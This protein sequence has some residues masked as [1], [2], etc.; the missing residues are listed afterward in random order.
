MTQFSI[1]HDLAHFQHEEETRRERARE[2]C[3]RE[4]LMLTCEQR[5]VLAKQTYVPASLV[6]KPKQLR[7]YAL[8]FSEFG[9]SRPWTG[10][11][12]A[13]AAALHRTERAAR[14]RI[15]DLEATGTLK[16]VRRPGQESQ[17]RLLQERKY[18]EIPLA[19]VLRGGCAVCAV[20]ASLRTTLGRG[21]SALKCATAITQV[22]WATIQRITGLGRTAVAEALRWLRGESWLS[23]RK[24]WASLRP[25]RRA[26]CR[27]KLCLRTPAAMRTPPRNED[28]LPPSGRGS[29]NVVEPQAG[30]SKNS[31]VGMEALKAARE[32]GAEGLDLL[33]E[34]RRHLDMLPT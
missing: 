32:S 8:L 18:V 4:M 19:L 6:N 13:I 30:P 28:G 16:V 24:V 1:D 11:M 5:L 15:R 17:Y 22:A 31:G 12:S 27:W 9:G 33:T 23:R 20:W 29:R 34:F 25:I 14:K 3:A 2:Q 21:R 26:V 10:P 7:T